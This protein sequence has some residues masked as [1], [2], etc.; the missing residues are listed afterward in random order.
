M[1]CPCARKREQF[2]CGM[3][4]RTEQSRT[5]EHGELS[6]WQTCMVLAS[7]FSRAE[8]FNQDVL[9]RGGARRS[10][11]QHGSTNRSRCRSLHHRPLRLPDL[12]TGRAIQMMRMRI[13]P[14]MGFCLFFCY[15]L[16]P[17]FGALYCL[18]QHKPLPPLSLKRFR[19]YSGRLSGS[20]F[21]SLK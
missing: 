5:K 10:R 13:H 15:V 3:I 2:L 19:L 12:Q 16:I 14:T 7:T 8:G 17:Y 20:R 11:Y 6:A 9:W 21:A 4:A 18:L 1:G